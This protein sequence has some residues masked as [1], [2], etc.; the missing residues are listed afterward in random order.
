MPAAPAPGRHAPGA[1][2]RSASGHFEWELEG[3]TYQASHWSL[4]LK[5]KFQAPRWTVVVAEPEAIVF[6]PVESFKTTFSLVMAGT[7]CLVLLLSI[8]QIRR[9]LVPLA[10]LKQGTRRI[11]A[12]D[13]DVRV[14]V[15]SADE[16]EE[17]GESFNWMAEQLA[18]QFEAISLMAQSERTQRELAEG[19]ARSKDAFLANMSHEIRTPMTAL[20][21]FADL[22]ADPGQSEEERLEC[23]RTIRSSGTRLLALMDNVLDLS[24][25]ESGKAPVQL[26]AC[27]PLE[28]VERV[29]A[30]ARPR[31]A[32]KGLAFR[33]EYVGS[34]PCAIRTDPARLQQILVHLTDNG[35]KF[36]EHGGVELVTRVDTSANPARPNLR[37]DVIDT[38]MGIPLEV[39][40]RIFEPF[41]QADS[42]LTRDFG[43]AGLGLA[44][45]QRFTRALRG[46]LSVES[47]PGAGSV[48]TLIIDPGPLDHVEWNRTP[49][50]RRVA[51]EAMGAT[52]PIVAAP[53][54][55]LRGHVLLTSC[56]RRTVRTTSA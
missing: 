44:I 28:V 42:S 35:I 18:A 51:A 20:L 47:T 26:A 53:P 1:M 30:L 45:A 5:A 24:S 31:A 6:Q 21:G 36:T 34:I 39:R 7:L 29:A 54:E 19:A 17:L 8:T 49:N 14:N 23:V 12:R 40:E 46:T 25:I 43:G 15:E 16:F 48:F 33:A 56:S 37:F 2:G 13:F 22:L 9:S 38:G 11:A 27:D 52:G 50:V 32:A 3:T 41:S 4:F 10:E 55:R